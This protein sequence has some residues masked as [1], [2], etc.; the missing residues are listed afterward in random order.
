MSGQ[1]CFKVP[2]ARM[3]G[4][5]RASGVMGQRETINGREEIDMT[6]RNHQCP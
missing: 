3:K 2:L 6:Q 1:K 4:W 5:E